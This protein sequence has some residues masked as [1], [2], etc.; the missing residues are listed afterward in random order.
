MPI[1]FDFK[2]EI[3]NLI[4]WFVKISSVFEQFR[5]ILFARNHLYT[6]KFSCFCMRFGDELIIKRVVPSTKG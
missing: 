5:D 3:L 1:D 2:I 6:C 4:S